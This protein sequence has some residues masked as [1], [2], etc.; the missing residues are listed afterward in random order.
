LSAGTHFGPHERKVGGYGGAGIA[1]AHAGAGVIDMRP[2]GALRVRWTRASSRSP[3]SGTAWLSTSRPMCRTRRR[4]PS[5]SASA[6]EPGQRAP[7][8]A[9]Q[10]HGEPVAGPLIWLAMTTGA[11]RYELC[12]LRWTDVFIDEAGMA[13]LWIRRGI[14]CN[15]EG[16]SFAT[17][18]SAALSPSWWR[19]QC[20][21]NV[22]GA[23]LSRVTASRRYL[24]RPVPCAG[25][26]KSVNHA[27]LPRS[28]RHTGSPIRR[29][30]RAGCTAIDLLESVA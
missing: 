27:P 25:R 11:R 7:A 12:A 22:G 9:D 19:R 21:G 14:S 2:S 8:S 28:A 24:R 17:P 15:A 18:A 26:C 1:A 10:C 13:V 16:W 29:M 6:G 4:S 20:W 23:R 30:C 5:R 3:A